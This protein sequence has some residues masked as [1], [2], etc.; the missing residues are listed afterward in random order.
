MLSGIESVHEGILSLD[1]V[2]N[3][4]MQLEIRPLWKGHPDKLPRESAKGWSSHAPLRQYIIDTRAYRFSALRAF[5][6]SESDV[7][8]ESEQSI[9]LAALQALKDVTDLIQ[10]IEQGDIIRAL[11]AY[12][13]EQPAEYLR[14]LEQHHPAA[15]AIDSHWL[16]MLLLCDDLW[17]VKGMGRDGIEAIGDV[18]GSSEM[19][20]VLQWP[21]SA[22]ELVGA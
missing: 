14:L 9:C 16:M 5:V 8:A 11:G 22:F 19:R 2:F 21:I 4:T 3:P 7:I 13:A 15:L 17:I 6:L 18:A 12:V 10:H 1:Q 20:N